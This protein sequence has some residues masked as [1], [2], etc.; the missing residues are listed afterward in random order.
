MQTQRAYRN[1]S[2]AQS[3]KRRNALSVKQVRELLESADF[4]RISKARI[5]RGKGKSMIEGE[6]M[7]RRQHLRG[8]LIEMWKVSTQPFG[9][10]VELFR[11]LASKREKPDYM[12]ATHHCERGTRYLIRALQTCQDCGHVHWNEDGSCDGDC[13]CRHSRSFLRLLKRANTI[14]RPITY[15]LNLDLLEESQIPRRGM[16]AHAQPQ[17]ESAPAATPGPEKIVE[18]SAASDARAAS[19]PLDSSPSPPGKS[20][21]RPL[22]DSRLE[23]LAQMFHQYVELMR[24][25][26]PEA[27]AMAKLAADARD[28]HDTLARRQERLNWGGFAERSIR[29]DY[30][31]VSP[32]LICETLDAAS[33]EIRGRGL[34][35]DEVPTH[36]FQR[37]NMNVPRDTKEIVLRITRKM[38]W[39]GEKVVAALEAAGLIEK[40][41]A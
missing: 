10:R 27:E 16:K 5:F 38:G 20:R 4:S 35:P 34:A 6:R 31:H 12:S 23:V 17:I 26:P 13:K 15:E 14:R 41:E 39:A 19:S 29:T 21:G 3:G 37:P 1:S 9:T 25:Y 33:H 24:K 2:A 28:V 11:A 7:Y 18:I 36:L 22:R 32:R 40:G 30:P 8:A